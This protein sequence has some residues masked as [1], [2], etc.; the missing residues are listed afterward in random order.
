MAR[1]VCGKIK[2]AA[3]GIANARII[4][5]IIRQIKTRIQI[6]GIVNKLGAFAIREATGINHIQKAQ[7]RLKRPVQIGNFIVQRIVVETLN[8]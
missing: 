7:T 4:T 2:I 6:V 8:L 5:N 1:S 3:I